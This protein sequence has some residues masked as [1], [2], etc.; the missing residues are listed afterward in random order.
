M[1][2]PKSVKTPKVL[3]LILT[4]QLWLMSIFLLTA[5]V[6]MLATGNTQLGLPCLAV[7]TILLPL[8]PFSLTFRFIALVI[9]G[10]IL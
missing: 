8:L 7:G 9:G 10:L 3:R 2:N 1:K 5:G 6:L 4:V